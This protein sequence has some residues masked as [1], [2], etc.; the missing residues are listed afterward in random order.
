[1]LLV[2]V[3]YLLELGL[4]PVSGAWYLLQLVTGGAVD[5]RA[6]LALAAFAAL[7]AATLALVVVQVRARRPQLVAV[8]QT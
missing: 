1:V 5:V 4:D 2:A 7:T 3:Y 6:T 8:P